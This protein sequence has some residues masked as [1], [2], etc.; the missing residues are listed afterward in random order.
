MKTN[1]EEED[2]VLTKEQISASLDL[3]TYQYIYGYHYS[4]GLG[5]FLYD[6]TYIKL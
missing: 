3:T 4:R 6:V 5:K 1:I 2:P